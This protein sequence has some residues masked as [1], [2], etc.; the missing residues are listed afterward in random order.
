MKRIILLSLTVLIIVFFGCTIRNNQKVGYFENKVNIEDQSGSSSNIDENVFSDSAYESLLHSYIGMEINDFEKALSE[1]DASF[2]YSID[3]ED[4]GLFH[5]FIYYY[6]LQGKGVLVANTEDKDGNRYV[7]GVYLFSKGNELKLSFGNELVDESFDLLDQDRALTSRILYK[8]FGSQTMYCEKETS[9]NQITR[10]CYLSI[11]GSIYDMEFYSTTGDL[12]YAT[13]YNLLQNTNKLEYREI[14]RS[15]DNEVIVTQIKKNTDFVVK[16]YIQDMEKPYG[17]LCFRTDQ[18]P[19]SVGL[20]P[21][22][23]DSENTSPSVHDLIQKYG[24]PIVKKEMKVYSAYW[25][26]KSISYL[27]I[28]DK[29]QVVLFDVDETEANVLGITLLGRT[30]DE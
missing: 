28:T 17:T 10:L 9:N 20:I 23:Y 14:C 2:L 13:C 4:G 11:D 24:E 7:K 26:S 6:D 19:Q 18:A 3:N 27:Y 21:I 8:S 29:G 5:R 12:Y 16:L 15:K 30:Y 22:A 1:Q 25:D